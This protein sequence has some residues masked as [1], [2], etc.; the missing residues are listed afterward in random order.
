[1]SLHVSAKKLNP[2]RGAEC[3]SGKR[4]SPRPSH[5]ITGSCS[6]SSHVQPSRHGIDRE[7]A[8][9]ISDNSTRISAPRVVEVMPIIKMKWTH[10]NGS[11]ELEK[12][13]TGKWTWHSEQ[14]KRK[15]QNGNRQVLK[16]SYQTRRRDT[17]SIDLWSEMKV[18]DVVDAS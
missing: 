15:G 7:E 8:E 6:D 10:P 4:S 13:T 12:Q 3:G 18:A 11:V 2:R 17:Y 16:D 14:T 5:L 1:M 9:E